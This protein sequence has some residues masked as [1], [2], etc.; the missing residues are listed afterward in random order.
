MG[1]LVRTESLIDEPETIE[2]NLSVRMGDSTTSVTFESVN[3][4]ENCVL[5]VKSLLTL[6]IEDR[7]FVAVAARFN[8]W[9]SSSKFS[10]FFES[11][12]S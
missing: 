6:C 1:T 11:N 12:Q 8:D 2:S 5:S 9:K 4:V 3:F 7:I 10:E